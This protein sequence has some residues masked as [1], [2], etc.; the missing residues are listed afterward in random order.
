MNKKQLEEEVERLQTENHKLC[1]LLLAVRTTYF[2]IEC[3][4]VNSTNWFDMRDKLLEK[5]YH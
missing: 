1:V 4:D 5:R 2:S 3:L